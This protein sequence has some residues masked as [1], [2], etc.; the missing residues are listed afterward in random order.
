MARIVMVAFLCLNLPEMAQPVISRADDVD[1]MLGGA[2]GRTRVFAVFHTL[3]DFTA[4]SEAVKSIAGLTAHAGFALPLVTNITNAR[5]VGV[6]CSAR[7][8]ED[9][10][11]E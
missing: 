11:G 9:A 1:M 5:R 3:G 8:L 2:V 6:T 7:A 10:R 4:V